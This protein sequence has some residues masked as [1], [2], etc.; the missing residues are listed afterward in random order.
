VIPPEAGVDTPTLTVPLAKWHS[1]EGAGVGV[2]KGLAG[3]PSVGV[4]TAGMGGGTPGV[5]AGGTR[6]P[7]TGVGGPPAVASGRGVGVFAQAGI[8]V[9]AGTGSH[10]AGVTVTEVAPPATTSAALGPQPVSTH[11]ASAANRS[12]QRR[13][14]VRRCPLSAIREEYEPQSSHSQTAADAELLAGHCAIRG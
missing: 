1:A 6:R 14:N 12:A 7:S 11:A 2:G 5:G 4:A 9:G 8:S 10:V 13:I 3:T